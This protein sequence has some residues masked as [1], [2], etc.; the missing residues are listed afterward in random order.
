MASKSSNFIV[1]YNTKWYETDDA[2]IEMAAIRAGG[3]WKNAKKELCGNGLL[4]HYK[5]LQSL[6]WPNES[7]T[8]WTDL[9]LTEILQNRVTCV[10]GPGS[11]WKTH[12]C[13][14]YAL[15]DYIC[16]PRGTGIIIS[17]T[18]IKGLER[19]VWGDIKQLHRDAKELYDWVPGNVVDYLHII[20]TDN[21]EE[22]GSRVMKDGIFCVPCVSSSGQ[23]VGMGKYVGFKNDRV[24]FIAD[25]SQFMAMS[26]LEAQ[27]NYIHNPDYK[28][29]PIGNPNPTNPENP[30]HF[31]ADPKGGFG[32]IPDDCKTKVWDCKFMNG[33]CINLDG[34]DSPNYDYPSDQP[35]HWPKLTN[36]TTL[37]L[38]EE[39]YGKES[40]Q[41][42]SQGCGVIKLGVA[43]RK[44]ITRELCEQFRALDG[45]VWM[46]EARVKI[47]ML[48]AAY[49][50]IGG[51]RCVLGWLEFG[52][53]SD[54]Q[55]RILMHEPIIVPVVVRKDLMAE[56]Q[57]AMFCR[58]QMEIEGVE[59]KNFFFDGR[60]SLATRI[61]ALWS[62]EVNAVEFGG[63]PTQRPVHND[64]YLVDKDGLRRLKRSDEHYSKFVSELWWSSRYAIEAD[65]I[66]GL[67]LDVIL[68]GTPREWK[69]V[70]GD[71]IE[72]ETKKDMKQR[73]FKSPDLY[74]MFVIGIEGARRRGFEIKGLSKSSEKQSGP[75]WLELESKQYEQAIQSQLLTYV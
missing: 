72:I 2:G 15:T 36:R 56:D 58:E 8:R 63:K 11:S 54:G 27:S 46:G 60:G 41:Y 4:F 74:D 57:I 50:G 6:F 73:T 62:A 21:I 52:T 43:G 35:V 10:V 1:K 17:S 75:G 23:F 67:T 9:I 33:R 20:A 25:E 26:F 65:Q 42:Y 13:A 49:S 12:T 70:A 44:I 29:I 53:C 18:D 61:A 64:M 32:S 39:T 40:E 66:R 38:I 19:R 34:R 24:R 31:I 48:D 37:K 28:F 51:D 3:T 47:G 30:L 7:H 71:K 68:D 22:D 45:I 14:K 69:K 5:A 55:S 59:P 16:F